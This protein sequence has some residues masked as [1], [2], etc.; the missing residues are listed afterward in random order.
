M[1]C[2]GWVVALAFLVSPLHVSAQWQVEARKD[3]MTDEVRKAASAINPSGHR[4]SVYRGPGGSAWMLFDV[5][6][7]V[8]ES[9]SARRAP[10]LR[11]DQNPSHDEDSSRQ[12]AERR[13]ADNYRWEPMFVN[14]VIWHGREAQGRSPLLSQLLSGQQLVVRYWLGTGGYRDIAFSLAGAGPA[15]AD[16]LGIPL[17]AAPGVQQLADTRR[18][19]AQ[20]YLRACTAG[21]LQCAQ[22]M[23]ACMART[24]FDPDTVGLEAC[25]RQ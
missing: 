7:I 1:K 16:A 8:G 11:V 9:I 17:A 19:I 24:E 3:A 13:L 14:F 10:M 6:A 5:S 23:S 2:S 20:A 22:R 18:L 21:H 4:I 12:L 15:I 25:L